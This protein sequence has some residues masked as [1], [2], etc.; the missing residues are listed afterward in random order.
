[1]LMEYS[2]FT[3]DNGIRCI[4]R[5]T[6][7]KVAYCS[8]SINSGTRDENEA[9]HGVA[10][11]T[12]HML[13]RGTEKFS[14]YEISKRLECHGGDINA[15]TGKE[16]TVLHTLSLV[17][18]FSRALE[19]VKQMVFKSKFLPKDIESEKEIIFDEINSYKDS[20][21]ELIFDD[22]EELIFAGSNL[23]RN[24]LGDKK[25]LSKIK[26]DDVCEYVARNFVT[27]ELVV[28]CCGN[29]SHDKFK[30]I[31]ERV[32]GDITPS[33]RVAKRDTPLIV[34][35]FDVVKNKRT[36]QVHSIL[37]GYA[38]NMLSADRVAVSMLCNLLGGPFSMSL[39]NQSLREK[40]AITYNIESSYTPYSDRG[41]FAIYYSCSDEKREQARELI[42]KEFNALCHT[43]LASAKFN[44]FKKQ[45]LGQLIISNENQESMML[46]TAKSMLVFGAFDTQEE[47]YKKVDS[48][49][50]DD[51]MR[52][53][54][55][56][57][58]N[59]N[60]YNL[61]YL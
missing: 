2:S 45:F 18:D 15:F 49:T 30:E 16:D 39:L 12:E 26:R 31:C 48:L 23:G 53:A 4:H 20:P 9:E 40:K 42:V 8:V 55:L 1:M 43:E 61:T 24:I 56:L 25:K 47:I 6:K 59:R 41:F 57:F 5:R 44:R 29:V 58:E 28:S 37:G 14:A 60:L 22:F 51:I 32:F 33:K 50:P 34:A 3:L 36:H 54:N 11:L 46:A 13:F 21:S 38:P 19:L 27:S 17:Q 52:V 10:H 35:P 7:S